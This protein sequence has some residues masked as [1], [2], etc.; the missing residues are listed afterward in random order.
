MT[1]NSNSAAQAV[2]L[3][4]A[5]AGRHVGYYYN[6]TRDTSDWYKLTT[7]ADGMISN[8]SVKQRQKYLCLYL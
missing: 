3:P 7:N 2:T 5:E 1:Q 4:L 6:N 8:H